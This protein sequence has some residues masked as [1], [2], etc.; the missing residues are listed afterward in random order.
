MIA[1]GNVKR[2]SERETMTK[3]RQGQ[4]IVV[5]DGVRV[6]MRLSVVG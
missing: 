2:S 5:D 6:R 4:S 3:A 1:D